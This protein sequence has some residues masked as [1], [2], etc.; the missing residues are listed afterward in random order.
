MEKELFLTI[1]HSG[2]LQEGKHITSSEI[3]LVK[4]SLLAGNS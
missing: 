2:L 1:Y 4:G 3:N